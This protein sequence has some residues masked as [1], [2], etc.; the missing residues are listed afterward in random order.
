MV[1]STGKH[2]ILVR[3]SKDFHEMM[4]SQNWDC[5]TELDFQDFC[6]TL[7]SSLFKFP[8]GKVHRKQFFLQSETQTLLKLSPYFDRAF[9]MSTQER[10]PKVKK[11]CILTVLFSNDDTHI[12]SLTKHSGRTTLKSFMRC[13]MWDSSVTVYR[14]IFSY[15]VGSFSI[16]PTLGS[17]LFELRNIFKNFIVSYHRSS[18][19]LSSPNA[20]KNVNGTFE[21]AFELNYIW[22][23]Q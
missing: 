4:N 3:T 9:M 12:F 20:Q 18:P 23:T 22:S 7:L 17:P 16:N 13:A 15:F 6:I 5:S 8:N 1:W 11:V 21:I 10:V 2:F 19:Q 14:L